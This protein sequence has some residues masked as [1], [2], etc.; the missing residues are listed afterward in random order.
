MLSILAHG[1]PP[2]AAGPA[3][4]GRRDHGPALRDELL[5]V[6]SSRLSGVPTPCGEVET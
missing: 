1:V 2:P 6:N 5:T 3:P 4:A